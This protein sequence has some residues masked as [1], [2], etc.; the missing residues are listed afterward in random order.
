MGK[1]GVANLERRGKRGRPLVLE[2]YREGQRGD[3]EKCYKA[4]LQ[5]GGSGYKRVDVITS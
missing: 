2:R 5:L 3:L 4:A 1:G